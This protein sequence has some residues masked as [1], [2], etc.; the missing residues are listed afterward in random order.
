MLRD[1]DR[2]LKLMVFF[3]RPIEK[4][5]FCLLPV[6]IIKQLFDTAGETSDVISHLKL[7]AK[8]LIAEI[9]IDKLLAHVKQHNDGFQFT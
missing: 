6:D 9:N 2:I 1:K 8:P 3:G 7:A 4:S 5:L